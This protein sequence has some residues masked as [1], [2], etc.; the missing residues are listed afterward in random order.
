MNTLP[1]IIAVDFDGCLFTNKWPDI[2]DPIE[3]NIAKLKGEQTNGAKIILWTSRTGV[4]LTEA[5]VAC[6]EQDI[7]FDAVNENIPAV[8]Y[9]FD[10]DCRKIFAHEYWDDRA[11]LMNEETNTED[12]EMYQ[13][14]AREIDL[15]SAGLIADY[16]QSKGE[17][18]ELDYDL[19]CY[20]SA[21]RAYKSLLADNH[22]GF[23][24]VQTKH[25]LDRLIDGKP[26]TPIE[27]VPYIW[28]HISDGDGYQEYQCKRMSSLFKDVYDDGSVRYSDNNR[29]IGIDV[30][31]DTSWHSGLVTRLVEELYPITMPYAPAS[32]P[33]KVYMRG[34]LVDHRKGD[35]DTRAILYLHT[36]DG[37]KIPIYRY[38]KEDDGGEWVEIDY[39]EYDHRVNK[40]P[41]T[42]KDIK[43]RRKNL[44]FKRSCEDPGTLYVCLFG[45]RYIFRNGKYEGWYRP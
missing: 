10:S 30:D 35:Y 44:M 6:A 12:S 32:K 25:I 19:G 31:T 17:S 39:F 45:K 20:D 43:E 8:T 16:D 23:S 28:N 3:K 42:K 5:L 13:W 21:F 33:Y 9:T 41:E 36:P 18:Q 1:R 34:S 29:A 2:G 4:R 11:V 15:V 37:E 24:I 7:C 40:T 38:F 26:L 14:A 27:D 22:S